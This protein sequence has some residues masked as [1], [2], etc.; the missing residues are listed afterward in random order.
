MSGDEVIK[1][2]QNFITSRKIFK[3]FNI[4][5][6]RLYLDANAMMFMWIFLFLLFFG[7]IEIIK[8]SSCINSNKKN[9]IKIRSY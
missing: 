5:Q 9:L 3:I 4:N 6:E 1:M 7:V 8:I 2:L